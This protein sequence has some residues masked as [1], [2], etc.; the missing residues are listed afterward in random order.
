MKFYVWGFFENLCRRFKFN[1]ILTRI[2]G[3]LP[4][5]PSTLVIISGWILLRK[6]DLSDE[7]CRQNQNARFVLSDLFFFFF[8]FFFFPK[9]A[10]FMTFVA[11]YGR[12]GQATN[13]NTIRRTSIACWIPQATNTHSEYV[14]RNCFSIEPVLARMRRDVTLYVHCLSCHLSCN[15]V[16][17]SL[18]HNF[19]TQFLILSSPVMYSVML[20]Y[21]SR[22][23]C[24]YVV[25]FVYHGHIYCVDYWNI[26][27]AFPVI[28]Y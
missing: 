18:L 24:D 21:Y 14:I 26:K 25:W 28:V 22:M 12:A 4:K 27:D 2:T 17:K 8:S 20:E 3:T 6:T 5:D 15:T 10:P 7:S 16:L 9:I 13:E 11:K 23:S 1:E 19:S